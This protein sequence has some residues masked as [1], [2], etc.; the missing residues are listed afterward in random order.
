MG[1]FSRSKKSSGAGT[2]KS[3]IRRFLELLLAPNTLVSSKRFV[4]ISLS[5][6][7]LILAFLLPIV[8]YGFIIKD[9]DPH[10]IDLSFALLNKVVDYTFLIIV[11]GLGIIGAADAIKM[12]MMGRVRVAE[13]TPPENVTNVEHVD[14]QDIKTNTVV[15]PG[16]KATGKDSAGGEDLELVD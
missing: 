6:D 15:N 7:F 5:V 3:V 13:N 4:I 11:I 10:I 2:D 9:R 14:N 12:V 16:K 8:V 1:L